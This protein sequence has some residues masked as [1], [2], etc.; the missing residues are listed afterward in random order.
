MIHG[1][2][3]TECDECGKM[4]IVSLSE[5]D[6]KRFCSEDCFAESQKKRKKVD[7]ST[8]GTSLEVVKSRFDRQERFFCSDSCHSEGVSGE[9]NPYFGETNRDSVDC[10]ECGES[11]EKKKSHADRGKYNFCSP[12]CVSDQFKGGGNPMHGVRGEEA[13]AW[14]GGYQDSQDWRRSAEW[15]DARRR[16][17]E[18]DDEECQDCGTSENLHVHHI[19][20]VS[21]GGAKFDTE[22]LVTLCSDHHYERH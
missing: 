21:E 8:C 7:C 9:G 16:V 3:E 18:R 13:P 10:D 6:S 1:R 11:F 15:F 20:P 14:K 19:Q 5:K 17:V 22:N 2:P 12:E 4:F